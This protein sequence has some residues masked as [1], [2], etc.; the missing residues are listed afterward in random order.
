MQIKTDYTEDDI[1]QIRVRI[2]AFLEL[3]DVKK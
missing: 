2:Q 3:M 1:Q